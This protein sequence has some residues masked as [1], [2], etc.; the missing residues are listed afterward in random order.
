MALILRLWLAAPWALVVTGLM[1][2]PSPAQAGTYVVSACHDAGAAG[3]V[4]NRSWG[5]SF[6]SG[7]FR[8]Y[9]QWDDC[10]GP[11]TGT[12][13]LSLSGRQEW[14]GFNWA[15]HEFQAP[16]GTGI[17]NFSLR[18]ELYFYN[19]Y[20]YDPLGGYPR[21]PFYILLRFGG[22]VFEGGG[23]YD[24]A[25]RSSLNAQG[26]WYGYPQ[27]TFY[28]GP[29]QPITKDSSGLAGQSATSLSVEIGC[30][31][32]LCGMASGGADIA[33]IHEAQVTINDTAAP[34]IGA[35]LGRGL[36]TS[37]PRRGDEPVYFDADDNAGVAKVELREGNTVLASEDYTAVETDSGIRCNFGYPAPCPTGTNPGVSTPGPFGPNEKLDHAR[38]AAGTHQLKLRV[39]DIGGNITDTPTFNVDVTSLPV[40][41]QQ[42]TVTGQATQ[43]QTLSAHDG[44]WDGD[45]PPT[46][47]R[48][49]QRCDTGGENCADIPGAV[50]PQYTLTADDVGLRIRLLVTASN[51]R[52]SAA[53]ASEATAAVGGADTPSGPAS[54][55]PPVGTGNPQGAGD[56]APS[57]AR[58]QPNGQGA[59]DNA[60]L[61]ISFVG[62]AKEATVAYGQSAALEGRLTTA[63]E[64]PIAGAALRLGDQPSA[65]GLPPTEGQSV[66]T[67]AE[68]SFQYNPPSGPSRL[69]RASYRAFSE[70]RTAAAE[71]DVRLI[72]QATGT[73]TTRPRRVRNGR[74][75]TFAGSTLPAQPGVPVEIQAMGSR[76]AGW[77]KVVGLKTARAGKYRFRYRF[78]RTPK[79]YTY[80]FR[81]VV[82]PL[83]QQGLEAGVSPQTSVKVLGR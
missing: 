5:S 59:A 16:S 78:R 58:G 38:L 67:D 32:S 73:L 41:F 39:T 44:V 65:P 23:Y 28:A 36:T 75:V 66:T 55:P 50:G 11:S 72:V 82:G 53:R 60:R 62:G 33:R 10:S 24:S 19:P 70:D 30:Y 54:P 48:R 79:T 47:A 51:L 71:A 45:P 14:G 81:V 69:I 12:I 22:Q 21:P 17:S 3:S 25:T 20:T 56:A 46:I 74:S 31:S 76:R 15:R 83:T 6:S 29:Q 4:G 35:Q 34:A 18:R 26:R 1:L 64:R 57:R 63:G 40:N 43:G 7:E 37:G 80:R 9:F 77:Q 52:G 42:P 49:W 8:N 61:A 2:A 27:G 68:G 13:G